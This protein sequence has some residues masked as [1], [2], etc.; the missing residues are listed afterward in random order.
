[1]STPMNSDDNV[2][3]EITRGGPVLLPEERVEYESRRAIPAMAI[4]LC[5]VAAAIPPLFILWSLPIFGIYY[6]ISKKSKILVTN[7]R[8][9]YSVMSLS[10]GYS[11]SSVSLSKIKHLT[12]NEFGA[13]WIGLLNRLF[14]TGDIQ[15]YTKEM[16]DL[17]LLKVWTSDKVVN[18]DVALEMWNIKNPKELI[19][20]IKLHI[21][22]A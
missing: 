17:E 13:F 7:K 2:V 5:L 6:Y 11:V 1:M 10:G 3:K 22:T 16:T 4:I 15:V 20:S 8:L 19:E 14:G 9:I 12:R 21:K 18:K